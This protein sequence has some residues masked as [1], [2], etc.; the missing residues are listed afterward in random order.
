MA[1]ALEEYRRALQ[2]FERRAETFTEYARRLRL[3]N[4]IQEADVADE[5]ARQAMKN[6]AQVW[7]ALGVL[8]EAM[9]LPAEAA[10][11]YERAMKSDDT[12]V[13]AA[14]NLA[15][16][17]LASRPD[18]S[19]RIWDELLKRDPGQLAARLALANAL[20]GRGDPDRARQEFDKILGVQP[21]NF[22]ARKG[23][24]GLLAGAG[25]FNAGVEELQKA[26]VQQAAAGVAANSSDYESLGDWNARLDRNVEAC[27]QYELALKALRSE[28][29]GAKSRRAILR[30]KL[31]SCKSR[32]H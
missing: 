3:D 22:E 13:A 24:A 17:H 30:R 16:L 32:P 2:W 31:L 25:G 14:H 4:K 18:E 28:S 26:M 11:D 27:R 7:N 9:K 6:R 21:D 12:L 15:L 8:H 20:A 1:S 23:V 5:R 29:D 10:S 19:I